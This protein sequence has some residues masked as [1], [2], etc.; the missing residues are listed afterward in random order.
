VK[1]IG[2]S[3]FALVTLVAAL[4]AAAADPSS[5]VACHGDADQVDEASAAIVADFEKDVHREAGLSCV[6][7]HGGNAD[8]ALADDPDAA[9]DSGLAD[10]PFVG[11]PGRTAIPEFC[12]RCHSDP[13]YMRRF[14][15]AARV[16]Q[17]REYWTSRHGKG[18]A[19]GD[20]KVATCVDCHGVHGIVGPKDTRSRI[21]PTHVAETCRSCHGDAEHMAGYRTDD[22]HPLPIDQFER[23]RQSVHAA[24]LFDRGDLSAP[25]CNDCHGNH[26]A[27]PP[28]LDSIA[29]VC[30]QCH[31]REAE[32]FRASAKPDLL[33]EHAEMVAEAGSCAECHED[34]DPQVKLEPPVSLSECTACHGNHAVVRPTIA[35][36]SPLPET[37]CAFCHETP[38]GLGDEF[39]EPLAPSRRFASTRDALVSSAP[40]GLEGDLLF[41][42]LVDRALEL[43]PHTQVGEEGERMLREEFE[44][45]F[46]KFRIG[47]R[48]FELPNPTTGEPTL[49]AVR[50]CGDCH[51]QEPTMGDPVGSRT[52]ATYLE[53]M[54]ELTA[55]TARSERI[56]LAARR[57]G[58]ETREAATAIDQAVDDQIELEVLVHTFAAG[59]ESEFVAKQKEGLEQARAAFGFGLEAL[60]EIRS[61]RQGLF[62]FLAF[63]ALALVALVLKI[64]SLPPAGG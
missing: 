9:M 55:L 6:D 35:M 46:Q 1:A 58:V 26:G 38:A 30:G 10:H 20:E 22:G 28:G 48:H 53:R 29:F 13:S 4:P 64:R 44:R 47:K 32:L 43:E 39:P 42:W 51:A 62:V 59:E 60:E 49:V 12:G 25:T 17:V 40:E 36:L 15:P 24:A 14:N 56:L 52:A 54:W 31:G 7:C 34:P 3:V 18:L 63:V 19:R 8:P 57:G 5:C 45:L 21:H 37:P 11:A 33:A 41:D 61:R 2:S 16:D 50:N 27:A 23:W